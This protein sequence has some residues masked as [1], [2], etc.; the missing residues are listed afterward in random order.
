[1]NPAHRIIWLVTV[2]WGVTLFWIPHRPPM[3]DLP[4]HAAQI[5]MIFDVLSP[6]SSWAQFFQINLATPYLTTYGLGWLFSNFL[7]VLTATKLILSCAFCGFVAMSVVLRK[8][9]GSDERLDWLSSASFFGFAW[10][11][12]FMSFLLAAPICLLFVWR[13]LCYVDKQ[14]VRSA[15]SVVLVGALLLISHGLVFVFACT[16]GLG[17]CC[18]KA[19]TH[20]GRWLTFFWPVGLSALLCA[21]Y[22]LLVSYMQLGVASGSESFGVT[23]W[24][25]NLFARTKELLIYSFDNQSSVQYAAATLILLAVPFALQNKLNRKNPLAYTPLIVTVI[26]FFLVPTYALKT[27]FLYQRFALFF[28]PAWALLFCVN[29]RLQQP[30]LY[31]HPACIVMAFCIWIPL[32]NHTQEAIKFNKESAD[33]EVIIEK[34]SLGRRALYFAID[35]Y[36]PADGHQN[37][38]LHYGSWYQAEK[39]GFVDFNFA[40]F[41]PQLLRFKESGVSEVRPGFEF[42]PKTF[43]WNTHR[44]ERYQYFIFRSEEHLAVEQYFRGAPCPPTLLIRSGAW[45]VYEQS[46]CRP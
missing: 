38:Y 10:K 17:I 15:L 46:R 8:Y 23:I 30:R 25:F 7:T 37:I 6:D 39:N 2:L 28:L 31:S 18:L 11:W 13:V 36:S 12:G 26:V 34:L 9:L 19:Y 41:P 21:V 40:W 33:F 35:N 29:T 24:A 4:Q 32:Y 43:D 44:G 3:V 16:I 22:S 5:G 42:Q 45:Y 20:S 1:M 14:S 27:A